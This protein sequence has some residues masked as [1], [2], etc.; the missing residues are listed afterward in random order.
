M[1]IFPV[2]FSGFSHVHNPWPINTVVLLHSC[3][4]DHHCRPLRLLGEIFDSVKSPPPKLPGSIRSPLVLLI[5]SQL[6]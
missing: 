1:M 6:P 3:L 5:H 2:S 4:V